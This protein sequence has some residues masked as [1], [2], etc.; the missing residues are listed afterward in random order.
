MGIMYSNTVCK[1]FDLKGDISD[2]DET[3]Y[4]SALEQNKSKLLLSTMILFLMIYT[5]CRTEE[6]N[7]YLFLIFHNSILIKLSKNVSQ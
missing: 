1:K 6:H 7:V 4:Y 5:G 3:L 2:F